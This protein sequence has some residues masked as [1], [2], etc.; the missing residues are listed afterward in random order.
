MFVSIQDLDKV[1]IGFLYS[2]A[3]LALYP[4]GGYDYPFHALL[5]LA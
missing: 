5:C 2:S 4:E 1:F 3:P